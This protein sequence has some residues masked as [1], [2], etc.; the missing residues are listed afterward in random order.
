M[1][2]RE[3]IKGFLDYLLVERRRSQNTVQSYQIDLNRFAEFLN[4]K[5]RDLKCFRRTELMDFLTYLK[6][7]GYS[8]STV[9]RYLST[10]RA[11]CRYMLLERIRRDDPSEGL[12]NPKRWQTLPKAL[13]VDEVMKLL[14]VISKGEFALRDQVM[15][16]LMY[17]SGLR[18]S[19]LVNLT[20]EDIS[21][22]GGFLRVRGK[23]GRE[24]AVPV[25]EQTLLKLKRYLQEMRPKLLKGNES[26]YLFLSNRG[27]PLTRQ[28]LWQA[29]KHYGNLA[30]LQLHP[31]VL[32]H[33]FATHLL[34]GGADLRSIQ[35]M[36]GHVDITTTQVYTKVTSERLK[37]VYKKY[38]PRA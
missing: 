32:R 37:R 20:V 9:C 5:G 15:L 18:V 33:S 30:G 28:R 17:A 14:S 10:I 2:D 26:P 36:L 25:S 11:V 23:G 35:R 7:R 16:E 12:Q 22:E 6:N 38:H 13:S 34:E 31:H 24:R 19:E 3:V 8:I 27:R 1:T 21:L 29:I 4:K